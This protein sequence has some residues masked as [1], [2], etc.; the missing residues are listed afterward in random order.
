LKCNDRGI[1]ISDFD[2]ALLKRRERDGFMNEDRDYDNQNFM[3]SALRFYRG[4]ARRDDL[5]EWV[6][7]LACACI[8]AAS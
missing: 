7:S 2:R 5:F 1:P 3:H 6:K 8:C 4:I